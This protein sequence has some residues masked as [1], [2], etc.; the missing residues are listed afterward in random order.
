MYGLAFS[1][2]GR[3]VVSAGYSDGTIKT[4]D[5]GSG[6]L[7][8]SQAGPPKALFCVAYSPD[9]RRIASGGGD[10]NTVHIWDAASGRSSG[11]CAG[12]PRWSRPWRSALIA[13]A[14]P[15]PVMTIRSR[16][17]MPQRDGSFA[18]CAATR[19]KS[20]DWR[21]APTAARSRPPVM[22]ARSSFGTSRRGR[23]IRTLNAHSTSAWGVAYS[24][25]GRHVA[26]SGSDKT[27]RIWDAASGEEVLTLLRTRGRG[28]YRGL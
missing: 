19:S 15:P 10:D 3:R 12:M 9:G 20:G 7:I 5:V 17:G 23:S 2:D 21:T 1:P 14:A 16:S 22:M 27:V 8:R 18:R 6:R 25:D 4:W 28:P 11:P 26:T 13:A 24:P